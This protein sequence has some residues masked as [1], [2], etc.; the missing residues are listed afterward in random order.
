M[1]MHERE[2]LHLLG[3]E[4]VRGNEALIGPDGVLLRPQLSGHEIQTAVDEVLGTK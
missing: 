1:I 2:P 3:G 4:R